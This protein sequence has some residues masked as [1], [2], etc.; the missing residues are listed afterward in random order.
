[1]TLI[2]SMP[3]RSL[4]KT[5]F[6]KNSK[7]F[8]KYF[9]S[10]NFEQNETFFFALVIG[11]FFS[12]IFFLRF[13]QKKIMVFG[14]ISKNAHCLVLVVSRHSR[15]FQRFFLRFFVF[16]KKIELFFCDFFECF[17]PSTFRS[18]V[19]ILPPPHHT[20]TQSPTHPPTPTHPPRLYGI[21]IT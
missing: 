4:F 16:S 8:K 3:P 1:M 14:S 17:R 9:F 21:T 19:R 10:K 2:V 12:D 5:S 20:P 13:F 15:K 7:F 6:V 11:L 18:Q